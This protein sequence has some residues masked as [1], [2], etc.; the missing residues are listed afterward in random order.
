[1]SQK[2]CLLARAALACAASLCLSFAF[3]AQQQTA[4][5]QTSP[6]P[7]N[8]E[9]ATTEIKSFERLEWRNIGPANMGGRI[10]DIEG[11]PG[12]PDIVYVATASGGLFKTTNGG[13]KW[14]PL[15]ERQGSISIGDIALEPGN[16]DV[17]WLGAGESAVRNS[18]SFGDGVYKSTDG[19]KTWQ[20]MGLRDTMHVSKIL[21]NPR[22]PDVVYVGALGH[23][24]GP[25]EERGVF[26]TT[27]GGETWA[28]NL[29]IDAEHGVAD[30]DIDPSNPNIVYAVM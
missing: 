22:N 29:Y 2:D 8:P 14:T 18:V 5:P 9:D 1:M 6:T 4:T 26:M 12:R 7:E 27:D 15:F 23:A 21:I 19:G 17:I 20:H 3:W 25:N 24:Y 13:V 28:K 10:A 11:V 16:P 30:M